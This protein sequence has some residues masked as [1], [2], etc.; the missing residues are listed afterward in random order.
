MNALLTKGPYH[1]L[2]GA[3]VTGCMTLL[4]V[5][6]RKQATFLS[7]VTLMRGTLLMWSLT[8]D[9][10]DLPGQFG[11]VVAA[12]GAIHLMHEDNLNKVPVCLTY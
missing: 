5:K 2:R 1:Q 10:S 9:S 11:S 4:S 6:V 12:L 3:K 8:S 7:Q